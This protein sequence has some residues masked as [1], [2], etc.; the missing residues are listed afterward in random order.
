MFGA[1]NVFI[2]RPGS[3]KFS[4]QAL[5]LRIIVV[6]SLLKGGNNLFMLT[7]VLR[8][9]EKLSYLGIQL[10]DVA[11]IERHHHTDPL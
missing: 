2:A 10:L 5:D 11:L 9:A 4:Y 6:D 7:S 1:Q 3:L 8:Q